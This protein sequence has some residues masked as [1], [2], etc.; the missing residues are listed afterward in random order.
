[1][2]RVGPI[3]VRCQASAHG[4]GG[5]CKYPKSWK[6]ESIVGA[7]AIKMQSGDA[8]PETKYYYYHYDYFYFVIM[9]MTMIVI[10]VIDVA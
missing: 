9:I 4:R 10:I 6:S 5:P 2:K 3:G 8:Y 1:M 7:C